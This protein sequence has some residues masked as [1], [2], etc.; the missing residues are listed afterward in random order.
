MLKKLRSVSSEALAK[1]DKVGQE[2]LKQFDQESS[3]LGETLSVLTSI[4]RVKVVTSV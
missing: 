2:V 1:E 4:S 3:P